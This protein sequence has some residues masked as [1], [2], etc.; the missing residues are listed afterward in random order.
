MEFRQLRYFLAVAEH[1]HFTVAAERLGIAQPPLSQQIIKLEREIGTKLFIRHPRRVELTE[2]GVVHRRRLSPPAAS[3]V[4][5]LTPWGSELSPVVVGLARWASR[6]PGMP[7]DSPLGTDSVML[8][9]EAL[10]DGPAAADFD[11][12]IAVHIGDERFGV[13]IADGELSV[14]RGEVDGPDATLDTDQATLLW[15]LR[16]DGALDEALAGGNLRLA[17]D[18]DVVERFRRLFPLPQPVPAA[19]QQ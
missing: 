7:Y 15:L 18:R 16:T 6:S 5:E 2:A 17:G 4:Y 10:F 3:W 8:S 1:L 14:R 9:L 11:T 13:R 19:G 12:T